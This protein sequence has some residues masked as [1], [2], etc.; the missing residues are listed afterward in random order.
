MMM[1]ML[2]QC[3]VTSRSFSSAVTRVNQSGFLFFHLSNPTKFLLFASCIFIHKINLISCNSCNIISNTNS[4][5]IPLTLLDTPSVNLTR[6]WKQ[7]SEILVHI[8]IKASHSC[9]SMIPVAHS[10][11]T[12]ISVSMRSADFW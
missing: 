1:L 2:F 7:C 12:H 5:D 11:T 10:T 4:S 8:D 3:P 9:C 6:C